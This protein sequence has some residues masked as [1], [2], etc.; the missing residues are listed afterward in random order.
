MAT[1][2]P[3]PAQGSAE[4]EACRE[5]LNDLLGANLYPPGKLAEDVLNPEALVLATIE[6]GR[7]VGAGVSRLLYPEDADYYRAF[8]ATALELFGHHR[9]GSLEAVAVTPTRQRQGI[10]KRL[11]MAQMDWLTGRGYDAAV[12]VS[13]IA[14]GTGASA[15]MYERLGFVGTAPVDDFYLEESVANRWTCPYCLGPCHC[16]GALYYRSLDAAAASENAL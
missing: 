12:A 6:A 11:T 3:A 15:P 4:V 16:A 13:W 5:L 1:M 8:G 10:G 7:V 2:A 14:G 9:V